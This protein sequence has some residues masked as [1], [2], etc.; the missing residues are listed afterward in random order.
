[1]RR[2][3]EFRNAAT[4]AWLVLMISTLAAWWAGAD[5]GFG[6]GVDARKAATVFVIVVAFVK[7]YLVILYFMEVRHAPTLLLRIFQFWCTA[8]CSGLVGMYLLM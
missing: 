5:H 3:F 6:D 8:V 4:Y 2:T 7:I 1:M